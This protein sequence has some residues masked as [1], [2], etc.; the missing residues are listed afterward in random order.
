ML[1]GM[2][3]RFHDQYHD[4]DMNPRVPI[5]AKPGAGSST[6]PTYLVSYMQQLALRGYYKESEGRNLNLEKMRYVG[7]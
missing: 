5:S 6:T 4:W 1:A 2:V 7:K 3:K